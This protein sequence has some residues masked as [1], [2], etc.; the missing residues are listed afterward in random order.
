M[1]T[2]SQKFSSA[3]CWSVE[4]DD[5][6]NIHLLQLA[7]VDVV[8]ALAKRNREKDSKDEMLMLRQLAL[9]VT[10]RRSAN[11]SKS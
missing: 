7:D 1:Q 10:L 3:F 5:D 9:V 11:L 8:V 4:E 2:S 6:A